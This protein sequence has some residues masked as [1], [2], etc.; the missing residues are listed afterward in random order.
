MIRLDDYKNF[1]I[2]SY[3]YEVD[4]CIEGRV[5]RKLLL[6]KSY[7]DERLAKIINDTVSFAGDVLSSPTLEYGYCSFEVEEDKTDYISLNLVGGWPSDTLFIDDN[8]REISN[9]LL[10]KVLGD[11]L[12]IDVKEELEEFDTG[13]E[14]ILS[15]NHRFYL[16]LQGFPKDLESVKNKVFIKK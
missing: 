10:H 9:H 16:Y 14:D 15:F 1:L 2:N 11:Y 6:E 5:K 13:D 7:N 8:G 3:H 12:Q 4:N